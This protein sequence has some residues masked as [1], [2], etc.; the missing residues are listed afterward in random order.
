ME[1][2]R[3]F[4]SV[5][6][7]RGLAVAAMLLVN[8]PGDWAHVYAPLLHAQWHGCTPTDL[9]FPV[10]LF[11]VGVSLA[12]G[13]VPR[14]AAGADVAAL[15]RAVLGR[16]AR[17]VVLGLVLHLL[18]W[19]WLDRP[20]FRPW[21]VLQ[22]IGICVAIA[23]LVALYVPPRRQWLLLAALLAGYALLLLGSGTLA[24]WRNVV[25]RIDTA[26]LGPLVYQFDAATGLGHDPEGLPSTLGAIA[27]TLLGLRAGDWLRAGRVRRLVI[28]ALLAFAAGIA[29][30]P[31]LPLNKNLWTP[32]YVL[33]TGGWALALLA[34]A[35]VLVDLRGLPALGRRFGV[36]AIAA[37]AG[38]AVMVYAL[39][40]LGVW[41]LAYRRGFVAWIAPWGGERLASLAFALAFVGLWWLVVRGMDRRGIHL[42]I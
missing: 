39:L 17:I 7:L 30:T 22:R 33:W 37:Y 35:H 8:N 13:L 11:V 38:S 4:A 41:D 40:G 32:S 16:A 1:P 31:W 20:Y 24:P 6:A 26:L 18:A 19:W 15:R 9:I 36:N 21:G 28:A 14:R 29:L 27:T 3:R 25:S 34:L 12:L 23:G 2:S 5:D 42:K 10:F